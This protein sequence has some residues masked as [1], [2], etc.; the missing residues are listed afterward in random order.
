MDKL[1]KMLPN[2][3]SPFQA[4]TKI[5]RNES[6]FPYGGNEI[7]NKLIQYYLSRSKVKCVLL[8]P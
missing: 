4:L 5:L 3:K 7:S 8:L 2:K 1:E 6:T